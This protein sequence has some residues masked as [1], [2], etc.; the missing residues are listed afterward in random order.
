MFTDRTDDGCLDTSVAASALSAPVS[1]PPPPMKNEAAVG[2]TWQKVPWAR[3][4]C[5]LTPECISPGFFGGCC[6]VPVPD[7]YSCTGRN[8]GWESSTAPL[9]NGEGRP[10]GTHSRSLYTQTHICTHAYLLTYM[11]HFIL[12]SAQAHCSTC[13]TSQQA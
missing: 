10:T 6:S 4:P 8:T 12:H 1:P 13:W 11:A 5:P 3:V 2:A 9:L 7:V